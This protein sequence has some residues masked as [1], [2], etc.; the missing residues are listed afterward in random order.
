MRGLYVHAS[1]QMRKDLTA[2]LQ[3]RWDKSLRER[4]AMD[5]HSPVPLLDNLL[6]PFRIAP[7]GWDP[8]DEDPAA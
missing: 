5:T 7:R 6:E 8:G 4:A 2:A 3:T 1:Q